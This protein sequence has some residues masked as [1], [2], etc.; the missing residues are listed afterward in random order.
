MKRVVTVLAVIVVVVIAAALALQL[1]ISRNGPA[2]LSVVDRVAG[3]A[4]GAE[5]KAI[6]ST[7]DHPQ[8]KLVVWGPESRD[9]QDPPIPVLVFVHGGSWRSGDPVDY[10][11]IGRAFVPEG[12]LV[13]LGGYRLGEDGIY[14]AMIEDTASVIRWVREEA[15]ELG[16]DPDRIVIA[17]HSAGAYNVAMVG[18]EEQWLESREVPGDAIAGVVGLSGPYDFLPFSRGSTQDAFGHVDDPSTTQPI[19]HVRADAPPM[20]L[21]HG[22]RDT[23]VKPRNTRALAERLEAAGS[24][25]ETVFYPEMSH[26]DPLISLAAP[27]RNGGRDVAARIAEFARAVTARDETSVPVQPQTR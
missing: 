16:G 12:F 15:G 13:V 18:L 1:T 10:G 2:V 21:I 3:G 11:F 14:P 20:L 17:G 5:Q 4:N 23:L 19:S 24:S 22:E 9:P 6:V 25:V 26:N 27:W 7:G 8:Q